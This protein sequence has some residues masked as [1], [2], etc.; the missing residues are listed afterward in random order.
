[1]PLAGTAAEAEAALT[2]HEQTF[3]G[4]PL[5]VVESTVPDGQGAKQVCPLLTLTQSLLLCSHPCTD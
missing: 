5:R 1:M 3:M 4:R 2:L